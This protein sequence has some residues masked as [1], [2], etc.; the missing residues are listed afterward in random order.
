MRSKDVPLRAEAID[1]LNERYV[2]VE[3]PTGVFSLEHR[4]LFKKTDFLSI[5]QN[6][7]ALVENNGDTKTFPAGPMWLKAINRRSAKSLVYEP[8]LQS[9][10]LNDGRY[11]LFQKPDLTPRQGDIQPYLELTKHLFGFG[12]EAERT[13]RYAEQWFAYPILHPGTKL[14]TSVIIWSPE[15]GVGKSLLGEV[16]GRLYGTNFKEIS[17]NRQLFSDFNEWAHYRCFVLAN[18]VLASGAGRS[19]RLEFDK[20]KNLITQTEL[21][22]NRKHQVQFYIRDC[23]N[24]YLTSN[25]SAALAL[26]GFDRRFLVYR[27]KGGPNPELGTRVSRWIGEK[28]CQEALL[29]Y[30]LNDVDVSDFN[31]KG[32]ALMTSDKRAMIDANRTDLDEIILRFKKRNEPFLVA[33]V[34][35]VAEAET[36]RKPSHREV[37]QALQNLGQNG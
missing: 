28:R 12:Y 22:I 35:T 7:S 10:Q 2:F 30:L 34:Q 9:G 33:E 21:E 17:G 16:I 23:I 26:D 5:V 19:D 13:L 36:D 31:P 3:N 11:N 1:S 32:N 20:L 18:E 8:R 24:Y 29:H 14:Y 4:V 15:Q 6:E 37:T 27:A 25:K